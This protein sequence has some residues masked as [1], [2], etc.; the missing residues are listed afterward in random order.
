MIVKL[1]IEYRMEFLSLKGGCRG[2][3]KS[4]L[5]KKSNCWK[6]HVAAHLSIFRCLDGILYKSCDGN[7]H[8]W[9]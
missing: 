3:S 7:G 8:S 5:V 2:L 4:T 1:L 6:S 9:I